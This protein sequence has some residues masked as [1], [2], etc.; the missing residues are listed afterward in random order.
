MV[1]SNPRIATTMSSI[2]R[3][4]MMISLGENGIL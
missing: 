4:Y 1:A 2:S 3:T